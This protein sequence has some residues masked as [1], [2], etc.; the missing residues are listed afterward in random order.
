[1]IAVDTAAAVAPGAMGSANAVLNGLLGLFVV[2]QTVARF[3]PTLR[4]SEVNSWFGKAL[5]YVFLYSKTYTKS[6]TGTDIAPA[7]DDVTQVVPAAGDQSLEPA[8][9]DTTAFAPAVDGDAA[10]RAINAAADAVVAVSAV[11]QKR[12]RDEAV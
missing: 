12:A 3:V 5:N 1:M 6:Q 11:V 2:V 10:M 7:G 9:A 8:P 4:H